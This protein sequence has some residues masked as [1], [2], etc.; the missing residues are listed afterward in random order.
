MY[1]FEVLREKLSRAEGQESLLNWLEHPMTQLLLAS[2]R[3][4]AEPRRPS[5][6]ESADYVLG[7]SR[8]AFDIIR[9]LSSPHAPFGEGPNTIKPLYGSDDI[10]A[11]AGYGSME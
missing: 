4:M 9:F 1:N 8:G 5:A 3:E 11:A 10:M 6:D 2:A 7:L